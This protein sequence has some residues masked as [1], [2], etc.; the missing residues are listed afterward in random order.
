M[1]AAA[2]VSSPTVVKEKDLI[3]LFYLLGVKCTFGPS[4]VAKV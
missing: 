1:T 3:A 2:P 4:S